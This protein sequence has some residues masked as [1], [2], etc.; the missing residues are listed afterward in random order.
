MK[1]ETVSLRRA[2]HHLSIYLFLLP[3]VLFIGTFMYYPVINGIYHSIFAWNGG[4]VERMV[5]LQNYQ[6]LFVEDPHFWSAFNNAFIIGM[7]NIVK[8]APSIIV[9]VCLHRVKSER[10]RFY[11]RVG[12]VVP[13]I[14]SQIVVLL[15]WKAFYEP[16]SGALNVLLRDSGLMNVLVHMSSAAAS[17]AHTIDP[18]GML[19][20]FGNLFVKG[21]DPAWLGS[22]KFTFAAVI[23]WGFPWVGSF[24]VLMYLACLDSIGK[25]IY[26]AAEVDGA[27]WFHK[28]R[29]IEMPLILRQVRV[30]MVLVIM[31]SINDAGTIMV[32]CGNSGGPGGVADVPAL[33]MFREAFG[34]QKMGFA[35]G[36]GVV[37][38]LIILT[39]TKLNEW[40]VKPAD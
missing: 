29:F 13:M 21:Q 31:G 12:F 15:L 11:Y 23:I 28:F 2:R 20:W 36:I 27:N 1:G 18:F 5:G 40:L 7:A 34:A 17:A 19:T 6:R 26:E 30:M 37:L 8:M 39:L 9:A 22:P 25:E 14:V 38:F 10:M 3:C 4:D 32:L 33:F 16:T 24:G 35:C